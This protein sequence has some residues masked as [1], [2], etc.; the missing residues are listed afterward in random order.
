MSGYTA[1]GPVCAEYIKDRSFVSLIEGPVGS[2]KTV[3]SIMKGM[4]IT[5]AQSPHEGVRYSRGMILRATYPEL[6]STVIKSFQ[7]WFPDQVAPIKWDSPIT[8]H[9]DFWLPDKTRVKAEILFLALDRPEDVGKLKSLELTWAAISEMSES[10]KAVFDMCTQRVGRYPPQRWG[11]PTFYGVFGDTNFPDTDHW[12]YK[13]FEEERPE[14]FKLYKQPGGLTDK[15]GVYVPDQSAENIK[16][17]P[18]GHEYYLRQIAGKAK[19]WIKVYACAQYGVVTTGKPVYSQY[20]DD[21]HVREIKPYPDK[22]LLLGLDF[23]HP[24]AVICQVSPTGQLRVYADLVED[25]TMGIQQFARDILKPF[26]AENFPNAKFQCVGDPAGVK[27]ADSDEK[28]AFQ[29]LA[30]EGFVAMPAITNDPRA[31]QE[32]VKKYLTKMVADGQPGFLVSPKA[33][34]IR[35][36]FLGGYHFKRVQIAGWDAQ[37]RDVP[38]K[39]EY[40]HAHDALQYVALHT[41]TAEA[42]SDFGKK[43]VYPQMGIV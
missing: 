24:A 13:T 2:G 28:T 1:S 22:P 37:Y 19:E 25:S 31:R 5:M 18:G 34:Y 12:I 14:G 33:T 39:N 23:G 3:G 38:N 17:L 4:A 26:L 8:A 16:N 29:I 6:K 30:A 36:G 41:Q 35:K 7:E 15:G 43:I 40:S 10:P 9:L 42:A 21:I 20:N 27:R 32:A 11:G